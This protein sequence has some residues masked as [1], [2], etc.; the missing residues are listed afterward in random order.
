ME[1]RGDPKVELRKH[2]KE[3]L[4]TRA[5]VTTPWLAAMMG[6]TKRKTVDIGQQAR[7]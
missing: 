4:N 5:W 1:Q 2:L 6:P 7:G 3:K